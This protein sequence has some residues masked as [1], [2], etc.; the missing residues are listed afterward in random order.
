MKKFISLLLTL[1]FLLALLPAAAMA[2]GEVVVLSPQRLRVNGNTVDCEKYNIDGNNYFKLRDV[3]LLLNGT[4]SQFSVAWSEEA[5]AISVVTGASYIPDGSELDLSGGD[6]SDTAVV[7]SQTLIIDGEVRSD[8]KAFNIGGNNFFKLRDLG[9]ALNFEVDYEQTS[10][11][12]IVESI[13]AP[14]L[15]EWLLREEKN[16]DND[17]Y[18]SRTLYTYDVFGHITSRET[19]S[20]G[21]TSVERYYYDAAGNVILAAEQNTTTWGGTESISTATTTS[22]FDESGNLL[23]AHYENSDGYWYIEENSYD[24]RGRR[25]KYSYESSYLMYTETVYSYDAFGRLASETR[26]SSP[27]IISETTYTYNVLGDL[28]RTETVLNSGISQLNVY[29]WDDYGN[30]LEERYYEDDELQWTRTN[31]YDEEGRTLS[32]SF[33]SDYYYS[34]ETTAYDQNGNIIRVTSVDDNGS[35][36]R[37]SRYDEAGNL[38]YESSSYEPRTDSGYGY[39][40]TTSYTYDDEG[41][42]IRSVETLDDAVSTTVYTYDEVSRTYSVWTDTVYPPATAFH[43]SESSIEIPVGDRHWIYGWFEPANARNEEL[44]YAV[45]DPSVVSVDENGTITALA[46]GRTVVS[47]TSES[48][49]TA[50]CTVTVTEKFTLTAERYSITLGNGRATSVRCTIH[51]EGDFVPSVITFANYD[52]S[53]VSLAWADAFE[54]DNETIPLYITG[55]SVGTTRVEVYVTHNGEYTGE[56]IILTVTVTD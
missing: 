56:T 52:S 35:Y 32:S 29:T 41:R 1:V 34:E 22:V 40:Q 26:S 9:D 12:A 55:L 28:T 44:T 33:S 5:R 19:T 47:V 39:F 48:G 8:L 30:L 17:G 24:S 31:T 23:S 7:S 42:L 37:V 13:P 6:K 4:A 50:S 2:E 11:T 21:Y 36:A 10:N 54:E 25:V 51:C 20:K 49:L 14:R 3:A 38:I 18:E 43:L 46:L 15:T 27:D 53:I 16:S 45:G